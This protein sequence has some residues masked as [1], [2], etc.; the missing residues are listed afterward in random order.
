MFRCSDT[1]IRERIT[2]ALDYFYLLNVLF[3]SKAIF[4]KFKYLFCL[5]DYYNNFYQ[6]D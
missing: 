3:K 1:I 4:S 5:K 2:R 6:N